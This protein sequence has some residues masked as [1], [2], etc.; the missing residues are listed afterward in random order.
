MQLANNEGE[1]RVAK[2]IR[3]SARPRTWPSTLVERSIIPIYEWD[4]V[5][6]QC[7]VKR[8]SHDIYAYVA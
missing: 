3:N 7:Q 5:E 8:G 6:V 4:E 2:R 1:Q